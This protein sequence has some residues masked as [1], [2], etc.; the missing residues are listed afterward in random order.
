[1]SR[2]K[3]SRGEVWYL[4]LGAAATSPPEEHEFM[5]LVVSGDDFNQGESGLVLVVPIS[6][7]GGGNPLH[8][9]LD[10]PEAG[11]RGTR[12]IKCD[13]VRSIS[14]DRLR[15]FVGV[16]SGGTLAAMQDRIDSIFGR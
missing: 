7:T 11:V 4:S 2:E 10:P 14:I 5:G 16:V 1:M 3:P 12:F 8:I 9:R 15:A 13:H 6:T